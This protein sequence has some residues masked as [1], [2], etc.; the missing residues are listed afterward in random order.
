MSTAFSMMLAPEAV[1]RSRNALP[2]SAADAWAGAARFLLAFAL[3]F[4]LYLSTVAPTVYNLDSAE[5]TTAAYTGGLVRATG[6]PL[7]LI[8]GRLW[9]R[10]PLGDIGL[11][12]NLMSA[13]FGALTI[14]LGDSLLRRLSI[15]A[16]ARF[17]SLGLLASS[18]YFW[19][20][21]S[22]AE[23]Y[24]LHTFMMT[25]VLSALLWFSRQPSALRLAACTLAVGLSFGNHVATV[26]L[27]PGCVWFV[28]HS[29]GKGFLDLRKI[30]AAGAGLALGMSLYLYLTVVYLGGPA[31]NYAGQYDADGVFQ[32]VDLTTIAGMWW[33]VSGKAFASVMAGYSPVELAGEVGHFLAELVRTFVGVGIGPAVVGFFALRR[34]AAPLAMTLMLIFIAT[35]GFYASYRVIDKDTMFLPAYLA[36]ALLLAEGYRALDAWL[37]RG[38][39]TGRS[40]T[41]GV[42]R[43]LAVGAVLF[44]VAWNGPLVDLSDDRSTY[45]RGQ[46]ILA[47]AEPGALIVGW[48][49]TVPVVE[50]LQMIE[51]ERP[52]VEALNRFLIPADD[53]K[54]LVEKRLAAGQPVYFDE[55]PSDLFPNVVVERQGPIFRIHDHDAPELTPQRNES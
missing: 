14:A 1:H 21:A 8:L 48:W 36:W 24:T 22:T 41:V 7:F 39:A 42:V 29:A 15:P 52:D 50:Y 31:F 17:S 27:A 2:A 11:R 51:G 30:A 49:S 44:A 35:V 47:R 54:Q 5:L 53:L 13:V 55:P 34:R 45:N 6:Y 3:P 26:L 37:V 20:M 32:A 28:V 16:W 38:D 10:L 25:V 4:V 9:S 33:L 19:A 40:A 12:M 43:V 23:V 18:R 46:A